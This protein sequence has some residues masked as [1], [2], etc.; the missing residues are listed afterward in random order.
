MCAELEPYETQEQNSG[1]IITFETKSKNVCSIAF[2]GFST[3]YK[4]KISIKNVNKIFKIFQ[5]SINFFCLAQI[6]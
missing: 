3:W 4:Y 6:Y 5:N 1:L 2:E